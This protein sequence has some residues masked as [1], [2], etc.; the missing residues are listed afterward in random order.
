MRDRKLIAINYFTGWFALDFF[1]SL[2]YDL[3]F[4][5]EYGLLKLIRVR[6]KISFVFG[7]LQWCV[8]AGCCHNGLFNYE[9]AYL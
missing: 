7:K 5:D 1:S 4:G 2:P 3:M 8:W 6:L 9:Y